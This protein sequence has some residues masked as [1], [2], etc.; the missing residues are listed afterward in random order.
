MKVSSQSEKRREERYPQNV[1]VVVQELPVSEAAVPCAPIYVSGRIQ[2]ISR[3][4]ICLATSSPIRLLS[5]IRC[6][7]PVSDSGIPVAT[8][9]RVRW[10]KKFGHL[11]S[12][13]VSGLEAIL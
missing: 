3:N 2:N 7:I 1:E 10:T 11:K 8:L 6:Q 4:G 9:M 5:V 12:G 13:F